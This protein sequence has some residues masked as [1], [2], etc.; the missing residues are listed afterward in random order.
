[1]ILSNEMR[2]KLQKTQLEIALELKRI[3]D[4]NNIDYFLDSGT[5]IGAIRHKGFIPWDDD[6]DVGMLRSEYEKF[7]KVA[8]KYL[9]KKFFL[10]TWYTDP[11]YGLPFA[12]IRM[13]NTLYIEGTAENVDAHAGIYI[14]IF[15]YDNYGNSQIKQGFHLTV[16]RRMI[17]VKSGYQQWKENSNRRLFKTVVYIPIRMI[18]L[19]FSKKFLIKCYER[20]AQKYNRIDC[21]DRFE[22]SSA[23]YSKW[24]V[25]NSD[26]ISTIDCSFEGHTFPIPIGYDNYLRRIYGDYMQL[27]P[28]EKRNSRHNIVNIKFED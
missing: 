12:K 2:R 11:Q 3:C 13:Q 23:N 22:N 15:P 8:P 10:Q 9:E 7:L 27:P 1:M 20:I 19:F 18:S 4:D 16:I 6:L 26:I 28:E 24:V 17:A 14:D 25:A 21:K 5:L